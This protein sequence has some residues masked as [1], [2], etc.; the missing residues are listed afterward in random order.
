MRPY[1]MR[2]TSSV[3]SREAGSAI[4]ELACLSTRRRSRVFFVGW[5]T[6]LGIS[7]LIVEEKDNYGRTMPGM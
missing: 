1:R 3:W 5:T 4:K 2:K 7:S 6:V